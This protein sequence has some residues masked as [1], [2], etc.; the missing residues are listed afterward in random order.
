MEAMRGDW[1]DAAR[2]FQRELLMK[3]FKR[4]EFISFIRNYVKK[5]SGKKV[6]FDDNLIEIKGN[7]FDKR[8]TI[9]KEAAKDYLKKLK[10][11]Y[12][13]LTKHEDY[14]EKVPYSPG[15]MNVTRIFINSDVEIWEVKD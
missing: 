8:S 9:P 3:L 4:E 13:Y 1:T 2:E 7:N 14:L 15:D 12:I 11:K 6:I 5:I 10:V